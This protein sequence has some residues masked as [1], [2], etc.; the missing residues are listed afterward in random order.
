PA[1][2]DLPVDVLADKLRPMRLIGEYLYE[3]TVPDLALAQ[4]IKDTAGQLVT[5][6]P[7]GPAVAAGGVKPQYV[8]SCANPENTA[9]GDGRVQTSDTSQ[10]TGSATGELHYNAGGGSFCSFAMIGPHTALSLAHCF[11]LNGAYAPSSYIVL[12]ENNFTTTYTTITP[13]GTQG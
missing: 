13:F 7:G 12:G 11:Y 8:F 9:A 1:P 5:T 4:R 2:Q 3:L 6:P 10:Y